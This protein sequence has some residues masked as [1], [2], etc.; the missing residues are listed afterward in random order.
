MRFDPGLHE[1]FVEQASWT[2]QAQ[3]LFLEAACLSPDCRVLEVGC[4]TGAVIIS[5]E[6]IAKACY[7]GTDIQLDLLEYAVEKS[8][9]IPFT[10]ADGYSL[11]Y[12]TGAFDAVFCHYFLLWVKDP[13]AILNEMR[14]VTRSGGLVAALAEPDYG[15]RIDYPD[16]FKAAGL[17]QRKSLIDYG[18]DPDSGRKV[19]S[20]LAGAGCERIAYG[21]FGAFQPQPPAQSQILSEQSLLE[22]DV[23]SSIDPITLKILLENDTRTRQ[24]NTRV[25]FIPTFFGWGYNPG[26]LNR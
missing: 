19:A 24:E 21:I 18:A 12:S 26:R 11:P 23:A 25:Q 15:S 5:L 2:R 3:S 1:R 16:E 13:L 7:T 14:R 22:R 17:A 8:S 20:L 10:C 6:T 4:G 9:T